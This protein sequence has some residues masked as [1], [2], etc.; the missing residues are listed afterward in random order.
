MHKKKRLAARSEM[1]SLA[2]ALETERDG[3]KAMGHALQYGLVPKAIEQATVLE[4]VVMMAERS[5][6]SLSRA[7]GVRLASNLQVCFFW[8]DFI[9]FGLEFGGL[10][11]LIWLVMLVFGCGTWGVESAWSAAWL[12]CLVVWLFVF[13]PIVFVDVVLVVVALVV[14][15]FTRRSYMRCWCFW[16]WW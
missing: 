3:H 4:R 11:C 7:S 5:L 12:G 8:G 2:K 14:L 6:H 15:A 1:I 9:F 13:L 10:S 16:R